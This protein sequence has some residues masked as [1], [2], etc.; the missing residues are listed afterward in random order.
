MQASNNKKLNI[1]TSFWTSVLVATLSILLYSNTFASES[2]ISNTELKDLRAFTEVYSKI[3]DEYVDV[4][5]QHQIFE[6]A[7]R[8]MLLDLDPHSSYLSKKEF[9]QLNTLSLGQYNGIGVEISTADKRLEIVGMLSGSPAETA[10]IQAG[11]IILAIDGKPVKGRALDVALEDLRG[12]AGT[13]VRLKILQQ[14]ND[15]TRNVDLVRAIIHV[16]AVSS[17][18]LENN[19]LYLRISSFQ[20]NTATEV[21]DELERQLELS[22]IPG[23]VLDLRDNPGGI[24]HSG[25]GVADLFITEGLIVTTRTRDDGPGM[26]LS[27]NSDQ[28]LAST[29]IIVLI[30]RGT[31][32]AAEIV[33]GA[34]QDTN[35]ATIMGEKSFGKG[36]IQ[37]VIPLSNG[38]ALK[39]TTALYYTPEGRSIQTTG[40]VPDVLAKS[41]LVEE[42]T[43]INTSSKSLSIESSDKND[44]DP[45][46]TEALNLLRVI[47]QSDRPDSLN[48]Y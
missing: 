47:S 19:Y 41:L 13:S 5:D 7:I 26:R 12:D 38:G 22:A 9:A 29:P 33:A 34:L 45:T 25:V 18:R 16:N 40:I 31:A 20:L 3:R 30:D 15:K 11:D 6:N 4:S 14:A 2:V 44:G 28:L 46:L 42:Q 48:A 35:R 1:F 23:L 8:G 10:K 39:L 32:S 36:S 21:R 37:S 27:A 17:R 24:L 43:D